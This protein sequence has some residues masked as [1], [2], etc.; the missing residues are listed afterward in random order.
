MRLALFLLVFLAAAN[1]AAQGATLSPP[2]LMMLGRE[3]VKPGRGAA[4]AA[5]L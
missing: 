5:G 1:L 4:Q 2:P 3:D